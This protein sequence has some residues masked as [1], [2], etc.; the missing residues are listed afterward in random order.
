M[1]SN[2]KRTEH[3]LSELNSMIRD[4]NV[5]ARTTAP[6]LTIVITPAPRKSPSP[7][8]QRL[9]KNVPKVYGIL[10]SGST[11][12]GTSTPPVL[13]DPKE[14]ERAAIPEARPEG[15]SAGG[16]PPESGPRLPEAQPAGPV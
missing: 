14:E 6:N 2:L 9:F 13:E 10:G 8:R 11:K 4:I 5:D 7:I 16:V 3:D 12:S 15:Q 1:N